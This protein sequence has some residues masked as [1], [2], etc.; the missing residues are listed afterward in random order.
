[1]P[2][3]RG[4]KKPQ[5]R[6]ATSNAA[7]VEISDDEE[8]RRAIEESRVMFDSDE[9]RRKELDESLD[10]DEELKEALRRS[11]ADVDK[12]DEMAAGPSTLGDRLSHLGG[13]LR[14][15][16]SN[17]GGNLRDV[18][19]NIGDAVR[20]STRHEVSSEESEM[21]EE[22]EEDSE[23]ESEEEE[24]EDFDLDTA[25]RNTRV[26]GRKKKKPQDLNSSL[27][28]SAEKNERIRTMFQNGLQFHFSGEEMEACKAVDTKLFQHQ[29]IGLAWMFN[30]EN[31]ECDGLRG[32]I[33]ADDM[34]LGKT[35]TVIALI[36]TNFWDKKP[37]CK[38]ELGF[39]RKPLG[40]ETGKRGKGKAGGKLRPKMS[41]KDLGIGSKMENGNKKKT[42]GGMFDKFKQP[43]S[44]DSESEK[45][46][47]K[48]FTFGMNSK[49]RVE[50]SDSSDGDDEFDTMSKKKQ[51]IFSASSFAFKKKENPI[52]IIEESDDEETHMSQEEIMKSMIPT[53]FDDSDDQEPLNPKLNVDGFC[54]DESSDED[55][56]P[57][58]RKRKK[59][60]C[61]D[62]EDKK[63]NLRSTRKKVRRDRPQSSESDQSL[64]DLDEAGG[65][66]VSSEARGEPSKVR[67]PSEERAE[68]SGT[69]KLIIPP[70]QPAE[71]R[72]RRR[73]TLVVCPTS[74]VSH[75]VEQLD[76]HLNRA[77]N[78]KL[79]IHHGSTKAL[80]GADLETFDIVITTYGVLAN[81][82]GSDTHSPLL[83]AKWLRVVLDEGHMIKNHL[84][85]T[86][87]AALNLDTIRKW[88][89]TG[90]PIQNNLLEFWSMI[91]WLKFGAYAG[92]SNLKHYKRD[93]IHLCK[94][95]DPKGFQRLQL[96]I[97][98]VCL[99]R[100]KTDKKPDGTPLVNLPTK[101]II[102]RTVELDEVES[103]IYKLYQAQAQRI[104]QK[105][106]K[107][108]SL[109]R[110]YAHI[111]ALMIRLRQLCCHREL[112]KEVDWTNVLSDVDGLK[113]QLE[114]MLS[115]EEREGTEAKS[116]NNDETEKRLMKQLRDMI[117][118]G[119]TEDCSICLDD[120]KTP[121]ITPCG[122]VFC[123][124]CIETVIQTLKPPTCPLCRG[125]VSK[126]ALLEAG[127]DDEE[128]DEVAK[129]TATDMDDIHVKVSSSKVNAVIREMLRIKRD[130]PG[131]KVVVVSQFTSFI[132]IIQTVI[133]EEGFSYVRLDG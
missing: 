66:P 73:A 32:G 103:V 92:K 6:A 81:E 84:T 65:S 4:K 15:G 21:S 124:A 52:D 110:N 99:R 72:G 47:R 22:S 126:K 3:K 131:E 60:L 18:L 133:R 48:T 11:L 116:D 63:G 82:F 46:N 5:T 119:V 16:L 49:K 13:N 59:R 125:A 118:S 97:D 115:K 80:T 2:P 9:K 77:V 122:H 29:Q 101:T 7:T 19:H 108:N 117:R 41:A 44:S 70:R 31:V 89:I 24:E 56:D 83:R 30:K 8:L 57:Q 14:D 91:N 129:T 102:T 93:I 10:D 23:E 20:P 120:L 128:D 43:D 121:V 90:T 38:P 71:R 51:S 109:L 79:K 39:T 37:L 26:R 111:F 132:S 85:K 78:I 96:L 58:P 75:W 55:K 25:G 88:I 86:A 42:F 33:L 35:L 114:E 113:K 69:G 106:S 54:E 98:A 87:K 27:L 50:S 107:R 67:E 127:Q 123:R 45:E 100:T 53:S 94:N 105:Y 95:G 62:E 64:P 112:I 104:V 130:H 17:I 68:S 36:L 61:S 12:Y 34:G 76:R 74:L 1:M 40:E 28:S